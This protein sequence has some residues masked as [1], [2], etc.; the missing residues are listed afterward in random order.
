MDTTEAVLDRTALFRLGYHWVGDEDASAEQIEFARRLLYLPVG[1]KVL[2]PFCGPGW[3]AHELAMWGFQVVGTEET[4]AFLQ[5]ARERAQRLGVT[6]AFVQ[7]QHLQLPFRSERFDGVMGI[8]N[9]CG[10]SGDEATDKRF[11]ME[12]A[13]VT[14]PK[15]RLVF[16]L[17]HRDGLLH[18]WQERDWETLLNGHRVL[19]YRQWDPLKGQMWEEW[20]FVDRQPRT[21]VVTYRV[22]TATEVEALLRECH[23]QLTNAFGTFLR[24]LLL[25][26]S[27]WMLIQCVRE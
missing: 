13:R 16:A 17:P 18:H 25:H 22:Y 21:F 7:V 3:Y 9:R 6:T 5:E 19:T 24:G 20:H 4:P 11:L 1:T 2:M 26:E 10:F 12:L 23:F 27:V 15:A 14:K 8:G